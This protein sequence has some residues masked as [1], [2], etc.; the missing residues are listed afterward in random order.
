MQAMGRG[1]AN[2]PGA[3]VG[4]PSGR[5]P[6]VFVGHGSPE[7]AGAANDFNRAWKQLGRDLPR[8]R[9]ILSLSAHWIIH[10]GTAVT[11]MSRPKTIH[12]FYGF[13]EELYA[14]EY[15]APG[16]PED[17]ALVRRIVRSIRVDPDLEWGL[18]HGTWSVLRHMYP[19][20][21]IPVLQLSL[22][23]SHSPPLHYR[24]GQ[25]LSV[26]RDQG[27]LIIGSGNLVHNLGMMRMDPEPYAWATEFDRMVKA[28]ILARDH[29]P[30]VRFTG[31]T[32][33]HLAHPTSEHYLPLLYILGAAGDDN[34][35]FFNETIF[36]GSVSMRGV[37]FGEEPLPARDASLPA[38]HR[39]L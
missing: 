20:A 34:P 1:V 17:A 32:D 11:A 26:L 4:T 30:L 25:E 9:L 39:E 15:D 28:R 36:A 37:V 7:N 29:G 6:V 22:N 38:T 18:D 27:V 16:S 8:P 2:V 31:L 24:I 13:P 21:D 35:R 3:G 5:M 23:Y 19:D 10:E 33:A 12:D 14:I